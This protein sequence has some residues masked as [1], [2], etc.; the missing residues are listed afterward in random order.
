MGA[1]KSFL[2][3]HQPFLELTFS[4][5]STNFSLRQTFVSLIKKDCTRRVTQRDEHSNKLLK[6]KLTLQGSS[7]RESNAVIFGFQCWFCRIYVQFSW[8]E[9]NA[10]TMIFCSPAV[11]C[12]S[13]F[14]CLFFY[15]C[16]ET[17]IA[18]GAWPDRK[19]SPTVLINWDLKIQKFTFN[20]LTMSRRKTKSPK[21]YAMKAKIG[22]LL[23][24]L[25]VKLLH[26]FI[27]S[28]QYG[29]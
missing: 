28:L 25:R 27:Y 20:K 14:L 7:G 5:L 2:S 24:I 17:L 15:F 16:F 18:K 13:S 3:E 26:V 29:K 21:M 8:L 9:D 19:N 10:I 1:Q 11:K 23:V 6:T 12:I 4:Y 22:W